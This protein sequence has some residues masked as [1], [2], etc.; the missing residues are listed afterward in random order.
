MVIDPYA[1]TITKAYKVDRITNA[2]KRGDIENPLP[3]LTTPAGNQIKDAFF[4]PPTD[5]YVDI[6]GFTQFVNMGTTS[7]PKWVIDARPYM[8]W[9]RRNDSYRLVASNDYSFQCMRL[10]LTQILAIDGSDFFHRLGDIPAKTFVRWVTLALAQ[11]YGLALEYQARIQAVC[12]YYYHTQLQDNR[13]L[14]MNDRHRLAPQV[15]RVT[16]V[17]TPI[18]LEVADQLGNL[19]DGEDFANALRECSG[20]VG[21]SQLKFIDLYTLIANSWI[22]V[23]SRE[24]VGV[25]LEHMPTFV[26]MVYAAAA[27]RSYRK[28]MMSRRV[29]TTGRAHELTRFADQLFRS[30]QSRFV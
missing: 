30:I 7:K 13:E 4:V 15:S 20:T 8:S 21:L 27:E 22:G 24:H 1:T 2:I 17:P 19:K 3:A 18:I 26:A 28:T 14:S 16:S 9:N 29:E 12:A 11:R 10:V 6:P 5:E 25:A 23:N